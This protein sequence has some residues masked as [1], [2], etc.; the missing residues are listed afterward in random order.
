MSNNADAIARIGWDNS[1][2]RKGAEE[3]VRLS[4]RTKQRSEQILGSIGSGIKFASAFAGFQ[5]LTGSIQQ[6]F[7]QIQRGF[8][9]NRTLSDSS[10]GIANVIRRFDGLN[11]TAAKNEAAKAL[12]RIIELEPVTAGGLQDLVS[13]FMGT[14][15]ASK[16]VGLSTMQ[17]ID[18]VAKFANALAN[19]GLPLDQIRQEFRSIVTSTITKDSQIAKILGITNEDINALRGNGD[20][21]FAFLNAKLGEFG[22]AG[23]SATVTLSSLASAVDKAL[24]SATQSLF[25]LAIRA[26]K[27]FTEQLKDPAYITRM[28]E[29]G[30]SVGK[31]AAELGRLLSIAVDLAPEVLQ[32]AAVL[33]RV[34]PLLVGVGAAYAALRVS[35][36]VAEK[37]ELARATEA[38][39]AALQRET[40]AVRENTAAQNQNAAAGKARKPGGIGAVGTM[41]PLVVASVASAFGDRGRGIAG[42]LGAQFGGEM[43]RAVGPGMMDALSFWLA[44]TGP[45]GAI[46]A[47]G[48]QLADFGYQI[49]GR[50][51]D[52]LSAGIRA[53][54][55]PYAAALDA[56]G[57][58]PGIMGQVE[59]GQF[60]AAKKMLDGALADTQAKLNDLRNNGGGA[61]SLL[62]VSNELDMLNGMRRNWE[63]I[64]A[65]SKTVVA[66]QEKAAAIDAEEREKREK[67]WLQVRGLVR[68]IEGRKIELLPDP[69]KFAALKRQL[70]DIFNRT[71]PA[72]TVR[73]VDDLQK[74]ADLQRKQGNPEGAM[75]TLKT[76]QE[77]LKITQELAALSDKMAEDSAKM[78]EE[79][80]GE[81]KAAWEKGRR[82]QVAKQ[83]A[84][85]EDEILRAKVEAGGQD[86]AAVRAKEDELAAMRLARQMEDAGIAAG[87]EALELA[88]KRV[89]QERALSDLLELQTRQRERQDR[90]QAAM[91]E[92]ED[93]RVLELR[94][95]GRDKEADAEE[96]K[97]RIARETRRLMQEMNVDEQKARDIATRKEAARE[98]IDAQQSGGRKKIKGFSQA[99]NYDA[100]G[101]AGRPSGP[102]SGG[103]GSLSDRRPGNIP[104]HMMGGGVSD[105]WALQ[106]G[107]KGSLPGKS[108]A[109]E[110]YGTPSNPQAD[111]AAANEAGQDNGNPMQTLVNLLKGDFAPAVAQQIAEKLLQR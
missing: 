31:T 37:R 43:G 27:D 5:G 92:G 2:A 99:L 56:G 45:K 94:A 107:T 22:E 105:F 55:D 86:S 111:Q 100:F 33:A 49:G 53:A 95:A 93:L 76:M 71:G 21:L 87:Q 35:R 70:N 17:N 46:A 78:R 62:A 59:A 91:M 9:F 47:L 82:V 11:K 109:A 6:G 98:K 8:D 1:D 36:W 85:L 41:G 104:A 80:A 83:E 20:A 12:Q 23:D 89:A 106:N 84:Q 58:M 77:A 16:G 66:E 24:G 69:E 19:A 30:E 61:E 18:L 57:A 103:S 81:A 54:R 74:L 10:V 40:A 75:A 39:A 26:A 60:E 51:G 4:Q 34:A 63:S 44:S 96:R 38:E 64:V 7:A 42:E 101:L 3:F 13:G 88:K 79:A 97:L 14:L 25:D 52:S 110:Y 108:A 28:Q 65:H 50:F 29:A 68:E 73:S 67:A 102:L 72:G 15:A 32:I 48:V 90:L